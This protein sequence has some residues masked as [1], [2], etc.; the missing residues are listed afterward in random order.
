[1]RGVG[2]RAAGCVAAVSSLVLAFS[3]APASADAPALGF[4]PRV[5]APGG[6]VVIHNA[7]ADGLC[8]P[9][10]SVMLANQ[11]GSADVTIRA[12]EGLY[13]EILNEPEQGAVLDD[14]CAWLAAHV[15]AVT[16]T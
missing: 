3:A 7:G 10:G 5:V 16:T 2:P 8:P 4:A 11:I 12:Y 14:I 13:H 9:R 15:G 6:V 1:M